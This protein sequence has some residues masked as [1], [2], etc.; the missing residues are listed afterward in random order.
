MALRRVE[1]AERAA[2]ERIRDLETRLVY[3]NMSIDDWHEHAERHARPPAVAPPVK[4][5]DFRP[6]PLPTASRYMDPYDTEAKRSR[7]D[8]DERE[9]EAYQRV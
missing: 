4:S 1:N 2:Q 3:A 7:Y 6:R 9:P 5:Y 8:Y